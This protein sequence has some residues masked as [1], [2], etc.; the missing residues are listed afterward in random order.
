MNDRTLH[1]DPMGLNRRTATA[2]PTACDEERR[3]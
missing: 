2:R 1:P 3:P